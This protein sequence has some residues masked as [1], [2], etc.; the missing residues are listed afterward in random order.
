MEGNKGKG[1]EHQHGR[2]PRIPEPV[3]KVWKLTYIILH[4][5]RKWGD[6]GH[7]CGIEPMDQWMDGWMGN[8]T[9]V[10]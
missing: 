6:I 1:N 8:I 5:V 2:K 3:P 10:V 7:P 4:V 9:N